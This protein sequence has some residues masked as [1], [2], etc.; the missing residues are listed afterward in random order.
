ME[1]ITRTT[2]AIPQFSIENG[3]SLSEQVYYFLAGKIERGEIQFG[4]RLNIKLIA[5]ELNV[6]SM[7]I[8]DAMKRLEQD[9]IVVIN[10]RSH[11]IVR[12]P[13]KED[14]LNAINARR[15]IEH[16]AVKSLYKDIP[17]C[18]FKVLDSILGK[19][20]PLAAMDDGDNLQNELDTYIE[21]D[22]Q[23]HYELCALTRNSYIQRF[24][25]Q[26]NMHLS[27]SFRYGQGVCHGAS[28]T[29]AE[30]KLL[31]EHLKAHSPKAPDIIDMHLL[32]SR[33]NILREPAFLALP[34]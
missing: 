23:F 28:A 24:Y 12:V 16:F 10:P 1:S 9:G 19:M 20:A 30:H 26:V 7:P 17:L 27:M 21:L 18:D 33:D 22:R 13:R 32:K 31:V 4:D 15:M 5:S 29:F 3:M 2:E 11:C 34:E 6:S 25:Q 14:V 8:R